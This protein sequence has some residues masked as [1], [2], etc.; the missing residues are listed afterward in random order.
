MIAH[1]RDTKVKRLAGK[2]DRVLV[3]APCTGFGTLRR[4]PDLKWRQTP[5]DA[6][7]ARREAGAI[8]AAAATLVKPGGRL[9]YA[10]CSVLPEENDAI[11]DAFLAAHP[12]VHASATRA[13][14]AR[15]DMRS[16]PAR[17]LRLC[18]T[19]TAATASSRRCSSARGESADDRAHA[20]RGYAIRSTPMLDPSRHARAHRL[21]R[22][23]RARIAA[24][25]A[26][27]RARR[28]CASP[29]AWSIDRRIDTR[30]RARD[31]AHARLP[32]SVVRIAFPLLALLLI[33]VA[34]SRCAATPGRRSSSTSR[35]RC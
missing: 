18:R 20:G 1:E 14:L 5:A 28:C 9:V 12:D 22:L 24:R 23:R 21:R 10:T 31:R 6:R 7:R 8:L 11:V 3:D 17:A 16:T 30:A 27:A 26:R 34:R 2:I 32:G 29:L 15:A 25:L 33:V 19:C 13:E 35:C 4:N